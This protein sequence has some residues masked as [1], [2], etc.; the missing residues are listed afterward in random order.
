VP[1]GES[2]SAVIPGEFARDPG[3]IEQHAWRPME[4]AGSGVRDD[5]S[6]NHST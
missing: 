4:R 3:S 2:N 5:T 6:I 1:K